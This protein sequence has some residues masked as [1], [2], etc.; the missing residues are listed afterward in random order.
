MELIEN[1]VH[2]ED[3]SVKNEINQIMKNIKKKFEEKKNLKENLS[4]VKGKIL[5]E[6]QIIDEIKRK[7]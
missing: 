3:C 7:T 2:F 1:L 6:K 5:I 4:Q